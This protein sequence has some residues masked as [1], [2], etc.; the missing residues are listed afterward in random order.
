[1]NTVD[2]EKDLVESLAGGSVANYRIIIG[3][4]HVVYVAAENIQTDFGRR[5]AEPEKPESDWSEAEVE[6]YKKEMEL[7]TAKL[8][9]LNKHKK[10]ILEQ[11]SRQI[12]DIREF[13]G[14]NL[15]FPSTSGIVAHGLDK[16]TAQLSISEIAF[17]NSQRNGA[18]FK[19]VLNIVLLATFTN[20][21]LILPG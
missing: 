10:T 15:L 19:Y 6:E 21:I 2:L 4:V 3:I 8:A 18:L 13:F 1:M 12:A 14:M 20:V 11:E 16:S 5:T 17:L 7:A 9:Y